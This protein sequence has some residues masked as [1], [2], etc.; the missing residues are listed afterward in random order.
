M[1]F[2]IIICRYCHELNNIFETIG[3]EISLV[4]RTSSAFMTSENAPNNI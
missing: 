1:Q 2:Y 4:K 3:V